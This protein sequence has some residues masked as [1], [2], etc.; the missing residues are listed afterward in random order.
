MGGNKLHLVES[1]AGARAAAA[2]HGQI[3]IKRVNGRIVLPT[4]PRN[5]DASGARNHPKIEQTAGRKVRN[6]CA[7]N[8]HKEISAHANRKG[9][10]DSNNS[11]GEMMGICKIL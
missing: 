5:M 7:Y 10:S 4:F 8:A 6:L 2:G 11:F 1:N 9:K 3:D